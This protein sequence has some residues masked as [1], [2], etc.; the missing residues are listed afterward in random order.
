MCST[1]NVLIIALDT[2]LKK[3]LICFKI[4]L[5]IDFQSFG[6]NLFKIE[7]FY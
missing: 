4:Y 1:S 7:E 2:F 6:F 5:R 3:I